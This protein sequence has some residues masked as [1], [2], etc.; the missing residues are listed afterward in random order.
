MR[1]QCVPGVPSDFFERLGTRLTRAL[2]LPPK[3][4]NQ[5][6]CVYCALVLIPTLCTLLCTCTDSHSGLVA[7]HEKF[8]LLVGT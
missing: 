8:D 2:L 4:V 6:I 3:S 7:L 1:E 5:G